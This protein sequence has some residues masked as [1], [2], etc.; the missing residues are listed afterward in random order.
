[1]Q[2][3]TSSQEQPIFVKA[4]RIS[5]HL[6]LA[7]Q[8]A[9]RI[10]ITSKNARVITVRA[11]NQASGY[12]AITAFIEELS[13][14]TYTSSHRINHIAVQI[15]QVATEKVRAEMAQRDFDIAT[16]TAQ[17]AEFVTSLQPAIN[18]NQ[19]AIAKFDSEF[20]ILVSE[21]TTELEDSKKQVRTADVLV[22][23]AKIEASKSG[24]FEAQLNVIASNLANDASELKQEIKAAEVI[25]EDIKRS[26]N[27]SH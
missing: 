1:M 6:H 7:T 4:A 18:N 15:S 19:A 16:T 13:R 17:N 22:S 2:P 26:L 10:S 3:N 5:A 9:Q 20:T 24:N 23:T 14:A 25:I 21:L 12:T 27:A 11:G 8:I